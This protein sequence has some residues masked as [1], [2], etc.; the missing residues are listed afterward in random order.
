MLALTVPAMTHGSWLANPT[1]PF[2]AP[3]AK[4]QREEE[5]NSRPTGPRRDCRVADWWWLTVT[6]PWF[7]CS[8]PRIAVRSVLLPDPTG[9]TTTTNPPVGMERLMSRRAGRGDW[10]RGMG[11]DGV[12]EVG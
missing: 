4:E 1:A 12:G 5:S 6:D 7:G 2:P 10:G 8:S 3:A 11:G 9:P